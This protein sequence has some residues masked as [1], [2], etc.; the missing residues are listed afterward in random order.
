MLPSIGHLAN[1]Q[2]V[3]N[4]AARL[5]KA[6]L[7]CDVIRPGAVSATAAWIQRGVPHVTTS[8]LS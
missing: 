7:T 4:R 8:T 6:P 2:P 1:E 5:R 3:K